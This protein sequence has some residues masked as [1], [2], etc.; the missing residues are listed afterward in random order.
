MYL[1]LHFGN[2]CSFTL[3]S[4]FYGEDQLVKWYNDIETER[5]RK[6]PNYELVFKD[7]GRIR[8]K[9]TVNT[10]AIKYMTLDMLPG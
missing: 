3:S 2:N 1:T 9:I 8:K 10:F 4:E 7:E 5:E 6:Y